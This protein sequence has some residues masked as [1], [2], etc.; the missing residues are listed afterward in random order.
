MYCWGD[1]LGILLETR[2]QLGNRKKYRSV[3]LRARMS[4][5]QP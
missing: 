2:D 3:F 5:S 1:Q 4:S